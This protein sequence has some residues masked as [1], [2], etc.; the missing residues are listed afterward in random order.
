M[1]EVTAS[2]PA[3]TARLKAVPPPPHKPKA[4]PPP[5][6][7]DPRCD[8]RVLLLPNIDVFRGN[9]PCILYTYILPD[10]LLRAPRKVVLIRGPQ[11][12]GFNIM[13]GEDPD[14]GIF[15]CMFQAQLLYRMFQIS[16]LK[17]SV[18]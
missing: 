15:I 12:L 11:G 7:N 5:P 4:V 18:Q 8:A 3:V 1:G 13:G 17:H 2:G 6:P 16:E 14:D 10:L 9:V